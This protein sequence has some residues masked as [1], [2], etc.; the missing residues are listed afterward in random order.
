M[1]GTHK[2]L[3]SIHDKILILACSLNELCV[4]LQANMYCYP[5]LAA[6]RRNCFANEKVLFYAAKLTTSM[7]MQTDQE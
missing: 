5:V 3:R 4:C 1:K 2:T 7:D 6:L